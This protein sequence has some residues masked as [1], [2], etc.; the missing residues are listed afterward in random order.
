M[1]MFDYLRCK[2]PLPLDGYEDKIFQTRDTD[3]Q[4]M[5]NYEISQEG[6][7]FLENYE[8][9]DRSDPAK[10]GMEKF[11]GMMTKVNLRWEKQ[12]DFTG[13][14]RFYAEALDRPSEWVE[15]SSYFIR[16]QIQSVT[17]IK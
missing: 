14:I 17:L 1:G 7:L 9:E 6:E 11:Y 2:Y 10:E 8:I 15:F 3:S 13:E 4:F 5:D 12:K 16:G